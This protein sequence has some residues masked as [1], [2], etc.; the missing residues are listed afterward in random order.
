[1]P[2]WTRRSRPSRCSIDRRAQPARRRTPV[3]RDDRPQRTHGPSGAW[4]L[5][6]VIPLD[7]LGLYLVLAALEMIPAGWP[8]P[9]IAAWIT[10]TSAVVLFALARAIAL[11]A[12]RHLVR[13]RLAS[14]AWRKIS[15]SQR[16]HTH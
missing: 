13:W 9:H 10:L 6:I 5:W 2:S 4:S 1:M 12:L 16:P 11:L 3:S 14:E 15:A 7:A 8:A